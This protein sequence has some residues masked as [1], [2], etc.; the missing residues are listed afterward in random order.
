MRVCDCCH[1]ATSEE[2]VILVDDVDVKIDLCAECLETL[3][4]RIFA[5]V[6]GH[7]KIPGV[8]LYGASFKLDFFL[9][10]GSVADSAD[11]DDGMS[12]GGEQYASGRY[13]WPRR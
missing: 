7:K 4:E 6:R 12:S 11:D 13:D 1:T 3:S 9:P 2:R 5:A 8:G 10:K